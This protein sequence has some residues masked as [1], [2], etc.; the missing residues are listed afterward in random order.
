MQFTPQKTQLIDPPTIDLS[1]LHVG[2][3]F[4]LMTESLAGQVRECGERTAIHAT[5]MAASM[6]PFKLGNVLECAC[7][8]H[9]I[10][11]THA[12]SLLEAR[13]LDHSD[14]IKR[15]LELMKLYNHS[16]IDKL[17]QAQ[18][19]YR[20][21]EIDCLAAFLLGAEVRDDCPTLSHLKDPERELAYDEGAEKAL[22]AARAHGWTVVSMKEDFKTVF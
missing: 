1:D 9:E 10:D 12:T 2:E 4:D 16:R 8:L 6:Q 21:C 18:E 5:R 11:I 13:S 19:I 22:A 15:A 3:A 20:A 7:L 17:H 14:P